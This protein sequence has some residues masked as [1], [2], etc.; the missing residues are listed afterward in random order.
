[1]INSGDVLRAWAVEAW[2]KEALKN[3]PAAKAVRQLRASDRASKKALGRARRS[4][5]ASQ[6]SIKR[7]LDQRLAE[8]ERVSRERQ[9]VRDRELEKRRWD[10]IMAA[11]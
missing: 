7:K 1:M 8:L 2:K 4:L 11:K 9:V 3:M 10:L 5:A 6:A